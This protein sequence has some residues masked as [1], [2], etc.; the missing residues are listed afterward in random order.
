MATIAVRILFTGKPAT[1]TTAILTRLGNRGWGSYGVDTLS[2]SKTLMD[3][4]KFDVVLALENLSDGRGYD[5][6]EAVKGRGN[7]LLVGIE[8]SDTHLWL[9]VVYHGKNVMGECAIN[10]EMIERELAG[11]LAAS[12]RAPARGAMQRIGIQLGEVPTG[13]SG[14]VPPDGRIFAGDRGIGQGPE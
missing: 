7:S 14:T 10:S 4:F 5:L 6:A 3:T 12:E 8:L 2:E 13:M 9:P 1:Q 11:L